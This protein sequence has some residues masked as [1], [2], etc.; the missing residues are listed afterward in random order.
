MANKINVFSEKH[1]PQGAKKLAEM[2][3]AQVAQFLC[4]DENSRLLP[5]KKDTVTQK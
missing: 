1:K 5:G 3:R 4:R 2:K